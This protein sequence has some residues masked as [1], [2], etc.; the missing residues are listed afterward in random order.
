VTPRGDKSG[1]DEIEVASWHQNDE[2]KLRDA[3]AILIELAAAN[4][5]EPVFLET[6]EREH[7]VAPP[8]L[9]DGSSKS[10][11]NSDARYK[12]LIEQI[13]AVVFLAQM[14]GGLGEAYVSPQI[15]TILGFTQEEWLSDPILWFRQLHPA[16]KDRWS[17]EAAQLFMTGAPLKST[18]RTLARDGKTIWFR[19]EVKMV[20]REN[21]EPWFIHGVGFDITEMKR[22]EELLEKAHAELETRVAERTAQLAHSNAELGRAMTEAQQA[23]RS[24]S[25]FLAAMSHEIRTPMNG[26]LGMTQ[27]LLDTP[28]TAEQ[29]EATETIKQSAD[30]L[31]TVI[32]D[33]LDF[34]KIEA[35][36][37]ELESTVFRLHEVVNGVL[38][39]LAPRAQSAGLR[40]LAKHPLPEGAVRGDPT[41]L[42]QILINLL[43]NAIKFTQR[44]SVT[45]AVEQ[46]DS[47]LR[48]FSI[49]DTGIGIP[50]EKQRKIFDPFTQADS[51]TLRRF[52]GTGLG[53]AI[54]ARLVEAMGGSI[55][56]ESELGRGTAFRFTVA[57]GAA[58][59]DSGTGNHSLAGVSV[60]VVDRSA[61]SR[62][63]LRE[64]LLR[65]GMKPMLC[66]DAP[67]ALAEF[68][69]ANRSGQPFPLV[70]LDRENECPSKFELL[71]RIRLVNQASRIAVITSSCDGC[72]PEECRISGVDAFVSKPIDGSYL[73]RVLRNLVDGAAV[74]RPTCD[75]PQARFALN[76][77]PPEEGLG[78]SL[79]VLLVEDNLVSQK[80]AATVLRKRGHQVTIASDGLQGL[81]AALSA[82][83]DVVLMDV[84]MPVMN[85]WEATAAIRIRE[86]AS[87]AHVPIIAMTAHAMKEDIDRCLATGMDGYVSKPFHIEDLLKELHRVQEMR[88]A[89]EDLIRMA[90]ALDEAQP[91]SLAQVDLKGLTA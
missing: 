78:R 54:S 8:R 87:G 47:S 32:N 65:L 90:G 81:N 59:L 76:G 45:I 46:T 43:G 84:Q 49:E 88:P 12:A 1:G 41:R 38:R 73:E 79:R 64:A 23:N 13:P 33:I 51:S 34:S 6:H 31:L 63:R 7:R 37:L 2:Q 67:R 44:G 21:G 20:R 29:R 11:L 60:L 39:L 25:D 74:D 48:R 9:T 42:R 57:L 28:L 30:A 15:E 24:K 16:D 80:V 50:I 69:A 77:G 72:Q 53:L 62:E 56:V 83:F 85:G 22:A 91:G 71:D 40:L 89:A 26:V 27:V 36:K 14:D 55:W 18:Y 35:G 70:L 3:E 58:A 17:V 10:I 4:F 86:R 5:S 19:C 61:P 82:T 75:Q 52:G 66:E 68:E